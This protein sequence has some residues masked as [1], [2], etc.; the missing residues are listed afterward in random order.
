MLISILTNP[1]LGK[2]RNV[3]LQSINWGIVYSSR[4]TLVGKETKVVGL[5]ESFP[6]PLERLFL[7]LFQTSHFYLQ[8]R[9]H[10]NAAAGKAVG[11]GEE[12]EK[13]IGGMYSLQIGSCFASG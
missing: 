11:T 12:R 9:A 4:K 2:E 3:K 5:N 1:G 8:L 7:M 13:S 10:G 6:G